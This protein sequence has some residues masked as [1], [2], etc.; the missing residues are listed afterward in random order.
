MLEAFVRCCCC[1][2]PESWLGRNATCYSA[3]G[4]RKVLDEIE[5]EFVDDVDD[6]D[7]DAYA[8]SR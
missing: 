1:C 7:D 6:L 5:M 8:L 3:R 2:C 4:R